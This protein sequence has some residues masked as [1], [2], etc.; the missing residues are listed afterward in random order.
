MSRFNNAAA[1]HVVLR[2]GLAFA[3]LYPPY[4]ALSDPISWESY[5]PAFMHSLGIPL[6]VL[7]HAF[8][9]LEA[10]IA[11]WILSG[12]KIRVP[13]TL[14]AVILLAI[15]SFGVNDFDILFRDL[16]IATIAVALALW[17]SV[18]TSPP[19]LV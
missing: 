12:W 18:R 2:L 4:A 5:F 17:P 14:A 9:A 6:I 11:L 13:A 8:G 1:A 10:A 16:T 3:F 15:V 7:L 19:P